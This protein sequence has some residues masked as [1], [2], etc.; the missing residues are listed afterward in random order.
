MSG[1]SKE[2]VF[3]I[4]CLDENEYRAERVV[5]SCGGACA[6]SLGTTGD[7]Y[8]WL[9]SL[10]HRVYAPKPSIVQLVT[11][12][13]VTKALAGLKLDA[14]FSLVSDGECIAEQFGEVLFTAYGLSGPAVFQ[15]SGE[16]S[17]RMKK[18]KL[19]VPVKACLRLFNDAELAAVFEELERRRETMADRPVE[20]I[21]LSILPAK[22]AALLLKTA[23]NRPLSVPISSL[24]EE[25]LRR[26]RNTMCSWE[27][28]VLGTQSLENAQTTIGGADCEEFSDSTLESKLVEGLYCCG[29]VL[30]VDGDCGGYNLQWAFSSGILAGEA[31]A[32]AKAGES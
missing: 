15:V 6:P 18:G 10:G 4:T 16:V 30:D 27:F 17:R 12:N 2:G 31:S 13:T 23:L 14:G 32:E 3:L 7:G 29:E 22:I 11:E 5:I 1:I 21:L 20:Q 28:E 8:R 24:S 9:A 26:I 19:T 25:D